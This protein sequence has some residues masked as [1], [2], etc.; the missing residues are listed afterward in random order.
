MAR[1]TKGNQLN[2]LVL[3]S[4]WSVE[5]DGFGLLTCRATYIQSHGNT[6]STR[7][8]TVSDVLKTAPKRG[9]TFPKDER[10]TCHRASSSANS[11]GILVV[12]AEYVGITAGTMT[13]PEVTGAGSMS[14][15]PISTHPKFTTFAGTVSAPKNGATFSPDGAF[16]KFTEHT[17]PRD[18]YGVKSYL[19]A[20]FSINGTFYT[21]DIGLASALKASMGKSS[22]TGYFNN[23]NLLGDLSGIGPSWNGV[24]LFQAENQAPQLLLTGI[25]LEFYGVLVKVGYDITFATDGWDIDIYPYVKGMVK[26]NVDKGDSKSGNWP[27]TNHAPF[28]NVGSAWHSSSSAW[29]S[30]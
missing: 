27:T 19:N 3:Q 10:L 8:G 9:D 7:A 22:D 15:E 21:K 18:K 2:S 30:Q 1:I 5:D 6:A 14:T 28:N 24:G 23:V 16:D 11:N 13:I 25:K 20:G 26:T 4:G 12:T 17:P 29:V